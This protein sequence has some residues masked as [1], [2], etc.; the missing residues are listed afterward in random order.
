MKS[1]VL[2]ILIIILVSFFLLGVSGCENTINTTSIA[3]LS[4]NP[5]DFLNKT[6]TIIGFGIEK[7]PCYYHCEERCNYG[8]ELEEEKKLAEEERVKKQA[9]VEKAKQEWEEKSAEIAVEAKDEKEAVATEEGVKEVEV[10][11]AKPETSKPE[12]QTPQE[13]APA[14]KT[15]QLKEEE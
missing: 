8:Y 3:K 11:E 15:E 1:D 5:E 4:E 14:E 2:S 10:K 12:K 6:V 9:E 13:S 7:I